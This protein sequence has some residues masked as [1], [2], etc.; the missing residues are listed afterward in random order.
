MKKTTL[1]F[2]LLIIGSLMTYSFKTFKSKPLKG[3]VFVPMCSI[4]HEN[5][6]IGIQAFYIAET[7]VTNKQYQEF[8]DELIANGETVKYNKAKIQHEN[9]ENIDISNA[10]DYVKT[11]TDYGEL[12]VV[13]ISQEGAELYCQWVSKKLHAQGKLANTKV[14]LPAKIEWIAAAKAGIAGNLYSFG[15]DYK[16]D[17]GE[18]IVRMRETGTAS[19]PVNAKSFSPNDYGLY[20]MSGNVAEMTSEGISIGGSWNSDLEGIK[21]E[22]GTEISQDPMTGFRPILTY[23]GKK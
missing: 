18:L 22:S 3:F 6:T 4:E 9:W 5:K 21:I 10:K 7:E 1:F 2:V 23:I 17:K 14:R 12:P 19:G 11:Y 8:L 20:N 15:N 13:N 16:N